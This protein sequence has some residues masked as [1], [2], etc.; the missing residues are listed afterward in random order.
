MARSHKRHDMGLCN[1]CE[2]SIGNIYTCMHLV[3][4]AQCMRVDTTGK[5]TAGNGDVIVV[6]YMVLCMFCGKFGSYLLH[7]V[8]INKV[9]I[10]LKEFTHSP[11]VLCCLQENDK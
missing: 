4:E 2:I 5:F 1:L 8:T 7:F 11:P 6:I 10:H 3:K 9:S